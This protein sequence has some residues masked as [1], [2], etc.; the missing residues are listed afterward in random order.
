MNKQQIES[1]VIIFH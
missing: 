1:A